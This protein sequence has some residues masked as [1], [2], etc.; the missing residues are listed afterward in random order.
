MVA[1]EGANPLFLGWVK[2][3]WDLAKERNT[4]GVLAYRTAHESL[5]VCPLRF[6]HPNELMALRGFGPKMC[7]RLTEKLALHCTENGL[8]M[9]K[10]RSA[11]RVSRSGVSR[12]ETGEDGAAAAAAAA[13][14]RQTARAAT[15]TGTGTRKRKSYVPVLRQGGYAIIMALSSPEADGRQWMGKQEVIELAQP[16]C[17]TSFTVKPPGKFYTAWD[18]IKTLLN[19]DLVMERGRPSRRYALTE[20]GWEIAQRFRQVIGGEAGD[21]GAARGRGQDVGPIDVDGQQ[22]TD[23]RGRPRPISELVPDGDDDGSGNG[24]SNGSGLDGLPTMEPI[25]LPA[26]SFTVQLV[27]DTRE[28]VSG[29]RTYMEDEL[30]KLGTRPSVRALSLGDALWV[31]KCHD[32]Q[33]LSRS[34]A[35]GDEV[36]LDWLIERKRQDDLVSSIRDGRFHEQK[37]RQRRCGLR[38]VVYVV[39]DGGLDADGLHRHEEAMRSAVAATQLVHGCFVKRTRSVDDTIAYLAR[40]TRVLQRRYSGRSLRVIPTSSLTARNYLPLLRQLRNEEQAQTASIS[41]DVEYCVT[42]PAFASLTSKSESLTLRD[43]YLKMLMCTRGVT[44]ERA[45]EVQ[46]RWRTPRAFVQAYEQLAGDGN[47][48]VAAGRKR[49][50]VSDRLGGL[51]GN[52]RRVTKAISEKLA[53]AWADVGALG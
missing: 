39:E 52:K 49:A 15:N 43:V 30:A 14:G 38:N 29:Q 48:V 27:L 4:K 45:L 35:E 2:E 12:A 9:P 42:Y 6:Q 47:D 46:K 25:E 19:N 7:S 16:H 3:W 13:E 32:A 18:S 20:E 41:R 51:A 44:A 17:D 36:V 53:E 34:G 50:M 21:G 24:S 10:K 31:A 40:L 23:G 1:D 26:G 33:Q 22:T 8:P 28:R 5:R 11:A 37:F